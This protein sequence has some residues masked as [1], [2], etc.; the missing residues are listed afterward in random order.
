MGKY[1]ALASKFIKSL[2]KEYNHITE[3]LTAIFIKTLENSVSEDVELT[4]ESVLLGLDKVKL[5]EIAVDNGQ[6]PEEN[7]EDVENDEEIENYDNEVD[8][9]EDELEDVEDEKD[10][11]LI[12]GDNKKSIN[13]NE[14]TKAFMVTDGGGGVGK[15]IDGQPIEQV[16]DITLKFKIFFMTLAQVQKK[17]EDGESEPDDVNGQTE[18]EPEEQTKEEPTNDNGQTNEDEPTNE[19]VNIKYKNIFE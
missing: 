19:S 3:Q 16:E 10:K 11:E 18:E 12:D 17:V 5:F 14:I 6:S 8:E 1:D 2:G 13:I 7:K 4:S 9:A 15:L